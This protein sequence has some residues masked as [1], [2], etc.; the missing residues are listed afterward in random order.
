MGFRNH[1]T[2]V[3]R[4]FWD[5][6][7][8]KRVAK[9]VVD[10]HAEILFFSDRYSIIIPLPYST[11]LDLKYGFSSM[12]LSNSSAALLPK[13]PSLVPATKPLNSG[14]AEFTFLFVVGRTGLSLSG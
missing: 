7:R 2:G 11:T 12:S 1:F 13:E 6:F 3:L 9:R 8:A 10:Y 4:A 5:I 14:Y